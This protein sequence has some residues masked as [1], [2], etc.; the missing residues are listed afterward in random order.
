MNYKEF[1][2]LKIDELPPCLYI[3]GSDFYWIRR[4]EENLSA[5]VDEFDFSLCSP[6]ETV[7]EAL[8]K[9]ESFPMMSERRMVIAREFQKL[10]DK[11]RNMLRAYAQDP[12]PTTVFVWVG[13]A[14]KGYDGFTEVSAAVND[15]AF[16][17]QELR[18][19]FTARECA[20]ED[21]ALA[22]LEEYCE[23]DMGAMSAECLKLASFAGKSGTVDVQAVKT[24]VTPSVS[25]KIYELG[26]VVAKGN[27]VQA[28]DL[29]SRL[30][31]EPTVVLAQ[32][33]KYY[34]NVFYAKIYTGSTAEL[35]AYLQIKPYP[36]TLASKTARN[37]TAGALYG[38][39]QLLYRLEWEIKS[40]ITTGEE[41]VELAFAQAIERRNH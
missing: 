8:L 12:T 36:L 1:V 29:V 14:V 28:Y 7:E 20:V 37:Y 40:G 23:G 13:D 10:T 31:A 19:F 39:L 4:V 35:A 15:K 27:Y 9:A 11:D 24:C 25:Y 18:S 3:T 34:R 41:A 21:A 6:P 22:L 38:L 32:L 16:L 26:D 5:M 17:R 30:G 33:T 2:A